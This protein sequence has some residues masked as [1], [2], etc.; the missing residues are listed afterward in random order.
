MPKLGHGAL[1]VRP[2]LAALVFAV[3]ASSGS[4][5]LAHTTSEATAT[6]DRG[7]AFGRMFA[8]QVTRRSYPS[9]NASTLRNLRLAGIGALLIDRPA[10]TPGEHARLFTLARRTKLRLLDTGLWA[11]SPLQARRLLGSN[12]SDF[13]V[14]RLRSPD[15]FLTLPDNRSRRTRLIVSLPLSMT[16]TFDASWQRAI[17][18]AAQDPAR[19]LAIAP[20]SLHL[21]AAMS[22][23]LRLV[24]AATGARDQ[25]PG[26]A[27]AWVDIRGG[28]CSR[29][30]SPAGYRN[31]Q[32]CGSLDSAYQVARPGDLI[33]VK[34]GAYGPQSI[35][36]RENLPIGS[37]PIVFEPAPGEKVSFANGLAVFSHDVTVDGGDTLGVDELDRFTVVNGGVGVC[38]GSGGGDW[39]GGNA[40]PGVNDR[41]N[42]I[43]NL[44]AESAFFNAWGTT[45]R[46]SDIGPLN[47]CDGR[48]DDLIK[49]WWV[50]ADETNPIH[51]LRIEYNLIHDNVKQGCTS[52]AHND[53][54]QYEGVGTIIRGNRIWN[55]GTQCIF[56]GASNT[57]PI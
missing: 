1:L 23:Y 34:G 22:G 31:G 12:R 29:S 35:E 6:I 32:A 26:L 42:V 41:N 13:V 37:T 51:D 30:A 28:S 9:L 16:T 5:S 2:V 43:E 36:N 27:N 7:Q 57:P 20:D 10:W 18:R 47:V 38:F 40:S 49:G 48:S 52:D 55:C 50:G 19:T 14:L 45:L 17:V 39:C 4:P 53:A 15:A 3:I 21:G 11:R 8:L 33:L 46:N 25:L 44:H 56:E 24:A 54:I